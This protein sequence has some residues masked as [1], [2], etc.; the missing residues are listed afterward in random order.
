MARADVFV[1]VVAALHND[2]D[3]VIDFINDAL[4]VLKREYEN[5]ELVLVDDGSTDGTVEKV[6]DALKRHECIRLILLSRRFGR[7]SALSAGLDSVIGDY[8][9]VIEPDRDPVELIPEIV[10]QARE[11]VGVVFGVRRDRSGDSLL[12]RLAAKVFYWYFTRVLNIGL[13]PNS[14]DYRVFSRQALNALIRMKDSLRYLRTFSLYVGYGSRSFTYSFKHRRRHPRTKSLSEAVRTGIS[15]I[16]ASS[17]H[18]LRS[19]SLL[20]LLLSLLSVAVAAYVLIVRLVIE[21]VTPGWATQSLHRSVMFFFLFLILSVLCEYVGR[22]LAE[23]R[24]R[25]LYH[26]IEERNSS[27]M[28]ADE[29]RKNVVT[30]SQERPG[31]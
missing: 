7:E 14:T 30:D 2:E 21:N 4:G 17:T 6:S 19:V 16:V 10:E 11:G 24:D 20:A 28:L 18:P 31:S 29:D 23:V 5:Y 15:M 1:S 12:K 9:V 25:P 22:L 27:V 13:T 26:V 8:I 3:I